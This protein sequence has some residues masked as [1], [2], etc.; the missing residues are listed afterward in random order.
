MADKSWRHAISLG[1]PK[2]PGGGED[3]LIVV[4]VLAVRRLQTM[5]YCQL[6]HVRVKWRSCSEAAPTYEAVTKNNMKVLRTKITRFRGIRE[7]ELH[8]DDHTLLV[9]MN[10]AGKSTFCEAL[11]LVLGPDRLSR[12]PPIDEH[13]FYNSEYLSPEGEA[14]ELRVEV[15][16][17]SLSED[18]QSTCASHVEW[19]HNT[20]RRLLA[21]GEVDLVDGGLVCACLRLVAIGKYDAEEDDFVAQTWYCHSPD[22]PDG[23]LKPVSKSVKRL[24]GFIYLRTLRTG[25]RA[26]SLERG[27]LLD[28]ILRLGDVR[29]DLWESTIQRLRGLH[30]PI[31]E[32]ADEL[33]RVLDAIEARLLEYIPTDRPDAGTRLFVSQLTREHL[34]KTVSFFLALAPDQA[35]IPFQ[36]VGTGTL[37][38]L[39]L[40]LLTIIAELKKDNVIFAMEE[41]E[42]ALPPHT[43]RRV[44]QYLLASTTQCFVTSHSPYVIER[45]EPEQVRILRRDNTGVVTADPIILAG[46]MKAK[47]YRKHARRGLCEAMLGRGAIVAEGLTEQVVLSAVAQKLEATDSGQYPLD[48]SGVTVFTGDGDGSLPEFGEFFKHLGL[49]SYAF[50][51]KKTRSPVESA[52]L[53]AAFDVL[54]ETAF[55][56]AE[57]LL[58]SEVPLA[59]QWELLVAIRDEG[60]AGNVGI[61]ASRPADSIVQDLTTQLLKGRKGDGT[62]GRLI[63]L[64]DTT[65]LPRTVVNFLALV[66]ADFPRP[67]RV[68]FSAPPT[69]ETEEETPDP[70]AALQV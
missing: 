53:N 68:P 66:Y 1:A 2:R 26:L 59:R 37:N 27:S 47:T 63:E 48:L 29:T 70:T 52:Q 25:S 69:T 24:F 64:C 60:S 49:R 44:V 8:F 16:V 7:A 23:E 9:G 35:P 22:L 18:I 6:V 55:L 61:P 33:R 32:G 19:W 20:E 42:I 30:P 56:G 39:V 43:Q 15:L 40:A 31:D 54:H 11:D 34:R 50:L 65:E 41:P 21:A 36:S 3:T 13:D 14:I 57:T 38:T 67:T 12:F 58:A 4:R 10:N 46:K 28:V 62:A 45:F 17:G 5:A 51:D